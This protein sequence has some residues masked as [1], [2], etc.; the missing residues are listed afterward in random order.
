MDGKR[1]MQEMD[2]SMKNMDSMISHDPMS[3]SMADMGA[4][5]AGK[6]GD[7]LNKA[8]LTGMITHHQ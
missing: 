4:M 1:N 7:D 3:M 6:T 8:F 2:N 5:L